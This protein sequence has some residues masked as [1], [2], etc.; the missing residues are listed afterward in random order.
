MFHGILLYVDPM[1]HKMCPYCIKG[2][3]ETTFGRDQSRADGLSV[4]CQPCK[5]LVSRGYRE[6]S[7]EEYKAIDKK[8]YEKHKVKRHK[9]KKARGQLQAIHVV[10]RA[11]RKG[12]LPRLGAV[13]TKCTDCRD[14]ATVYDHRDYHYPLVV[15]PVCEPCNRKRGPA[16]YL[17]D[18]A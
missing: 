1:K 7:P 9:I 8:S 15:E 17:N 6:S 2:P 18:P 12:F 4:Y 16:I 3:E 5:N 13:K 14:R 10:A 11:V